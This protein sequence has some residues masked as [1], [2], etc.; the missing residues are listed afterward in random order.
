MTTFR[1]DTALRALLESQSIYFVEQFSHT[2]RY[3]RLHGFVQD[4]FHI[5]DL[6]TIQ[7]GIRI[8]HYGI[9]V[10]TYLQPRV[11]VSLVL[12]PSTTLKAAWGIYRQSPGYERLLDQNIFFDLSKALL[13][14][15]DAERATHYVLGLEHW[16]DTG[17]RV[18]TEAY[19]KKYEDL[20]VQEIRQGTRFVSYP[21]PGGNIRQV[22]GWTDPVATL[23]DSLTPTPI[24]G[25]YGNAYG[26][27]ILLAKRASSPGD[28]LS[29]WI[30]YSLS[31][32]DRKRDGIITPFRFDRRHSIDIVVDY[33]I[34][35]W[36][37]AGVKWVYGSGFPYTSP[38]SIAPRIVSATINGNTQHVV[39]RDARGNTI[40]DLDYGGERN[41]LSAR[42]PAYHRLDVRL[43]AKADFWNLDWSFY[44]DVINA[45]NHK[46]VLG[47]HFYIADDLSIKRN[48][49]SMF[50]VL[51]TIGVS[52]RF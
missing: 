9:N 35:A 34:T 6:L 14:T 37:T 40:L 27:E 49:L 45:Y 10:R 26:V 43:T 2:T 22:P 46:N 31:H 1:P 32:S 3:H 52:V 20:V 42:L 33:T 21:V 28:P 25:A 48:E 16:F 36:L 4:N 7:P 29:G 15:L 11:N 50:P 44:L 17:W 19:Y 47:Y 8:E 23:V 18:T 41:R 39:E 51:P 12:S 24:N 30:G 13:Q 38:L 5:S